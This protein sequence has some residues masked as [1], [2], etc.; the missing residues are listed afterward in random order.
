MPIHS[1]YR[2]PRGTF[3]GNNLDGP[4]NHYI[5]ALMGESLKRTS[6][7][8]ETTVIN[9]NNVGTCLTKTCQL[10]KIFQRTHLMTDHFG[11]M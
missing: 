6:P 9:E 2:H 7:R 5:R 8:S 10:I 3:H 11:R 1:K 4:L